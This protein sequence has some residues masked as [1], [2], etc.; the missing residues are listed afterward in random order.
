[1]GKI[2]YKCGC[3]NWR[4]NKPVRRSTWYRHKVVSILQNQSEVPD[5]IQFTEPLPVEDAPDQEESDSQDADLEQPEVKIL[6]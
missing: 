5:D 2:Y 3:G 4:C 1:M 6:A